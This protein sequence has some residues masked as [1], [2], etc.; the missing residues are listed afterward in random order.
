MQ[1]TQLQ[2]NVAWTPLAKYLST[3][4]FWA[5]QSCSNGKR[6]LIKMWPKVFNDSAWRICLSKYFFENSLKRW[7][8]SFFQFDLFK[9]WWFFA[10]MDYDFYDIYRCLSKQKIIFIFH[11]SSLTSGDSGQLSLLIFDDSAQKLIMNIWYL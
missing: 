6:H 7:I 1:I 11:F 4:G 3:F 5:Q 8:T 2:D 10:K 9:D